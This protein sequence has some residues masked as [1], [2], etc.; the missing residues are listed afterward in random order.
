MPPAIT[1]QI[2]VDWNNDGDFSD[3]GEDITAYVLNAQWRLGFD[4]PFM[5][6]ADENTCELVLKNSDKR[7]S[8]ENSSGPYYGN[9]LPHR[10]VR[11]F[12]TVTTF[13]RTHWRG[14]VESIHPTVL[15]NGEQVAILRA[16]GAKRFLDD[17]TIYLPLMENVTADEIIIKILEQ[18]A[19]PPI[20]G[21][22]WVLGAAGFSELGSTTILAEV[23]DA[24][25]RTGQTIFP[26]VGDTFDPG[27]TAYEAIYAVT[28]TERGRFFY[29]REGRNVFW[30]RQYL[31]ANT[32][33]WATFDDTLLDADYGYGEDMYNVVEV[34]INPRALSPTSNEALWTLDE[35]IALKAG[36]E[37]TIRAQFASDEGA[38]IAGRSVRLPDGVD[39]VASAGCR[40]SGFTAAA[41]SAEITVRNDAIT[42]GTVTTIVVRGQKLTTFKPQTITAS[43]AESV[44]LYGRRVLTI[45]AGMLSDPSYAYDLAYYLLG[46]YKDPRGAL[47]KARLAN[48]NTTLAVQMQLRQIGERITINEAQTGHSGQYVIMGQRHE[49]RE[50]LTVW[51]C[52]WTLEPASATDVWI[53]GQ[54]GFSELGS[55]TKLGF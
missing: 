43:D 8:P 32:T 12:S 49:L 46:L 38:Q 13:Q 18:V 40:I 20:Q 19:L 21:Q 34:I 41:T 33:N 23:D 51:L 10:P 52:E 35:P 44:A 9:L 39:F 3:S 37:R 55:T 30:D 14:W 29:N 42:D 48:K 7:F 54:S 53:L 15:E 2:S 47:R 1:W 6:V 24:L 36:Q 28:S 50:G 31:Q 27:M 25:I 11:I 17:A 4:Q 5:S 45:D 16:H 22:A 26:Y